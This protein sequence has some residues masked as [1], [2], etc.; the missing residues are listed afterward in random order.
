MTLFYRSPRH[1]LVSPSEAAIG[2]RLSCR[3]VLAIY[4]TSRCPA[5]IKP[6][7][8]ASLARVRSG[9]RG[10]TAMSS[11]TSA[12]SPSLSACHI[13]R[14]SYGW[15]AVRALALWPHVTSLRSKCAQRDIYRKYSRSLTQVL[16]PG[17]D[18]QMQPAPPV[19]GRTPQLPAA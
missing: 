7:L 3:P 1:A 19:F 10:R 12:H 18:V 14:E 15:S 2:R 13:S 6:P 5:T 8:V 17:A 9:G 11:R 16:H 4:G